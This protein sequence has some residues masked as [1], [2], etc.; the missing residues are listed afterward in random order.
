MANNILT[1]LLKKIDMTLRRQLKKQLSLLKAQRRELPK[2]IDC[3]M[4]Y[5]DT[6]YTADDLIFTDNKIALLESQIS[7]LT[8]T[9]KNI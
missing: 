3:S 4:V 5:G 6:S 1:K 8:N 9:Q 7:E 2:L